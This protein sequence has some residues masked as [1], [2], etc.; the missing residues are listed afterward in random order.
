MIK[1][2]YIIALFVAIYTNTY[3]DASE[4]FWKN[5]VLEAFKSWWDDLVFTI[6]NILWY[7]VW[8]F[9]FIAIIIWTYGWFQIMVSWWDEEKF[10]KWKNYIIYMA[11]WLV[12][13]FLA[14]QFISW[15]IDV[16][17]DESIVWPTP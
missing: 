10:K 12:I 7:I 4:L 5:K 9:Y 17:S 8:L 1:I 13:I 6:D 11:L 16:M 3:A 15:I 14:S 2:I